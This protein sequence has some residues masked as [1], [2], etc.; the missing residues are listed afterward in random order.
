ML[1]QQN[2]KLDDYKLVKV[3]QTG[4]ND[5]WGVC[6]GLD[7]LRAARLGGWWEAQPMKELNHAS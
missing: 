7:D 2:G 6:P 3:R 5:T 4:K 1:N